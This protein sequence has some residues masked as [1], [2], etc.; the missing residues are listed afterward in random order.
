MHLARTS[1]NLNLFSYLVEQLAIQH[2]IELLQQ[3]H[4]Q[5]QAQQQYVNMGLMPGQVLGAGGAFN[6][7]QP[8]MA[9]IS[10]QAGFQFPNQL[11]QQQ[12]VSLNSKLFH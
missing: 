11:Q 10:P 2:Q 5:L 9:N 6:P 12:N 3:Q 8:T 1:T 7:L 4:Q